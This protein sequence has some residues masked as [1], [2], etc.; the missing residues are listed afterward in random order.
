[1]NAKDW[2]TEQ[3]QAALRKAGEERQSTP[4]GKIDVDSERKRK[5]Q[6]PTSQLLLACASRQPQNVASQPVTGELP[7][8]RGL[9]ASFAIVMEAGAVCSTTKLGAQC[10]NGNENRLLE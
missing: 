8:R 2:H 3:Q 10:I 5:C 9:S 1:M 7:L 6:L 4:P